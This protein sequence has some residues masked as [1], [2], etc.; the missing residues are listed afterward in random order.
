MGL[1]PK[2]VDAKGHRLAL[3]LDMSPHIE[4]HMPLYT[5][6][7]KPSCN[8]ITASNY[9]VTEWSPGLVSEDFEFH[10]TRK[11]S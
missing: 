5:L 1:S 6:T 2:D 7:V 8:M 10:S 9:F 4:V 11:F 3:Y